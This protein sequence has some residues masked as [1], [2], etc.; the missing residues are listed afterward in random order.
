MSFRDGGLLRPEQLKF[1]AES[2]R[3]VLGEWGAKRSGGVL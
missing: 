2:G 3:G 1:K